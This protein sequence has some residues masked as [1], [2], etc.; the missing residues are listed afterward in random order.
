MIDKR[1]QLRLL[2]MERHDALFE[3][4]HV[5]VREIE[6]KIQGLSDNNNKGSRMYRIRC[7]KCRGETR[8]SFRGDQ[9]VKGVGYTVQCTHC[10]TLYKMLELTPIPVIPE[11]LENKTDE[12]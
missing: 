8:V 4:D 10:G 9:S 7:P 2:M 11:Q 6:K 5:R 3:G 1:T 12:R